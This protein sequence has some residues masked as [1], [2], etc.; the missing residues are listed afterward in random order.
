MS[1]FKIKDLANIPLERIGGKAK[2]LARISQLNGFNV[3][4][5]ICLSVECFDK[6]V[7]ETN[8]KT[9]IADY[10]ADTQTNRIL[11][12]KNLSEIRNLISS[13]DMPDELL[14]K[15][16]IGMEEA[17]IK[18]S[19]GVS[20]RSSSVL[21]DGHSKTYAGIFDSILDVKTVDGLKRAILQVWASSYSEVAFFYGGVENVSQSMAVII[22]PMINGVLSGVLFTKVPVGDDKENILIEA[23]YKI[24]AVVKG[25][26]DF[27]VKVPR[28]GY[29]NQNK[30]FEPLR[31][32]A[33]YAEKVFGCPVDLEWVYSEGKYYVMQCRAIPASLNVNGFTFVNQDDIHLCSSLDLKGC[34]PLFHRFLGKQF[35]FR[36]KSK[37][38]GV[39]LYKQFYVTF[40]EGSLC[41]SDVDRLSREFTTDFVIVE[42]DDCKKPLICPVS[43]LFVALKNLEKQLRDDVKCLR[44]GELIESDLSGY[45]SLTKNGEIYIEYIPGRMRGLR[46]SEYSPTQLIFG[47]NERY[48]NHSIVEC[49]DVIDKTNGKLARLP[50]NKKPPLLTSS[51]LSEIVRFTRFMGEAFGEARLEWYLYNGNLFAKD[52]S[53]ESSSLA[54]SLEYSHIISAGSVAGTSIFINDLNFFDEIA[55]KYDISI[56]SH[57][58][59]E[60][61]VSNDQQL[62]SIVSSIKSLS[63]NVIVFA[64][65]PSLGLMAICDYV[66]GFVFRQG[67]ILSHVS[68]ILR[69]KAIPSVISPES[70]EKFSNG[71][72]VQITPKGVIKV[73]C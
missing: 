15:I 65:R 3:A 7:V 22:Q 6:F 23:A 41:E 39:S 10:L 68:I 42:H 21:E 40:K 9:N 19:E 71:D 64:D 60:R 14:E 24:G 52:I 27:S 32:L 49:V 35:L 30:E 67:S 63:K 34:K 11:I 43:D 33:I 73:E 8:I 56:V 2:G 51:A 17:G 57:T 69:E 18:L 45:S 26:A 44:I 1:I 59:K 48:L 36:Q 20:V 5:G 54:Y 62:E 12:R 31:D 46:R 28:K 16:V 50:Y 47:D 37:E 58:K 61:D 29:L 72:S 38:A 55:E 53:I 70:F 13:C 25:T 66:S 4:P